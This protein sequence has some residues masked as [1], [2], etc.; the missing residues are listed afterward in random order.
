MAKQKY[1]YNKG[2]D[3][4]LQVTDE[5]KALVKSKYNESPDGYELLEVENES[6]LEEYR[7]TFSSQKK[8][9]TPSEDSG[10]GSGEN[11]SSKEEEFK[12]FE[13]TPQ[14]QQ[15]VDRTE[16]D[17]R[18]AKDSSLEVDA[19]A[20]YEQVVR[21]VA[22]DNYG[23]PASDATAS[24]MGGEEEG[25]REAISGLDQKRQEEEYLKKTGFRSPGEK[26]IFEF[27]EASKKTS[28]AIKDGVKQSL[29]L[30]KTKGERTGVIESDKPSKFQ[31]EA[32]E[33][34]AKLQNTLR[35]LEYIDNDFVKNS[36]NPVLIE[37]VE[38]EK[39]RLSAKRE[40]ETKALESKYEAFAKARKTDPTAFMTD[41]QKEDVRLRP[42]YNDK[43]AE[44][45][46]NI[47][48]YYISGIEEMEKS[49]DYK[50]EMAP[51][52]VKD[53]QEKLKVDMATYFDNL[54]GEKKF[55]LEGVDDPM[56]RA[57]IYKNE[58]LFPQFLTAAAN[59]E[60][61]LGL[62][63]TPIQ[64]MIQEMGLD[65]QDLESASSNDQVTQLFK[66]LAIADLIVE[67]GIDPTKVYDRGEGGL[68]QTGYAISQTLGNLYKG[69]KN[70]LLIGGGMER[71]ETLTNLEEA[72]STA[73]K[74]IGFLEKSDIKISDEM[75][76]KAK[77]QTVDDI[78]GLT[79]LVARL[80]P[81]MAS[82]GKGKSIA[83]KLLGK[84]GAGKRFISSMKTMEGLYKSTDSFAKK[85]MYGLALK[86]E[87]AI[88]DGITHQLTNWIH[89]EKDLGF[90]SGAAGSLGGQYFNSLLGKYNPSN[91]SLETI[92]SIFSRVASE[93]VEE[94]TEEWVQNNFDL[95]HM[96]AKDWKF[97]VAASSL[98]GGAFSLVEGK[99]NNEAD[100]YTKLYQEISKSLPKEQL[101]DI[102]EKSGITDIEEAFGVGQ[103]TD[104]DVKEKTGEKTDASDTKLAVDVE[105]KPILDEEGNQ[106]TE[107]E[108]DL[109]QGYIAEQEGETDLTNDTDTKT[110]E[111]PTTGK[112]EA[113]T[114]TEQ[115][116][117]VESDAKK[118]ISEEPS[119][120]A[121]KKEGI[122]SE[123]KVINKRGK[124]VTLSKKEV[125]EDKKIEAENKK[126][127]PVVDL[128]KRLDDW[129]KE[130]T[131]QQGRKK[132]EGKLSSLNN[133]ANKHGYTLEKKGGK[134][135]LTQDGEK[136]AT[137]RIAET[138]KDK[139]QRYNTIVDE[140]TEVQKD[141]K[142]LEE[143]GFLEDISSGEADANRLDIS[144]MTRPEFKSGMNNIKNGVR[145]S[146][147]Q[148][149]LDFVRKYN[150]EGQLPM[151]T[152]KGDKA[153]RHSVPKEFVNDYAKKAFNEKNLAPKS[154]QDF[155]SSDKDVETILDPEKTPEG[156]DQMTPDEQDFVY[157]VAVQL[158]N[159]RGA[160]LN[161][162]G[163]VY[164]YE[165]KDSTKA[166]EVEPDEKKKSI[167]A[168][169]LDKTEGLT[170][171]V[172]ESISKD[173]KEYGVIT[174]AKAIEDAT[175]FIGDDLTAAA[176]S[177]INNSN[178]YKRLPGKIKQTTQ[179][180]LAESIQ[181]KVMAIE[182]DKS[183]SESK[184]AKESGDLVEL[185]GQVLSINIKEATDSA[186]ALQG[187]KQFSSKFLE[188]PVVAV[189]YT[190]R[191]L[192]KSKT[193]GD[194]AQKE[195][196]KVSEE[197]QDINKEVVKEIN[198]KISSQAKKAVE[199]KRKTSNKSR[200]KAQKDADE[201]LGS[202]DSIIKD[203]VKK[204]GGLAEAVGDKTK[205]SVELTKELLAALTKLADALIRLGYYNFNDFKT[206]FEKKAPKS[207]HVHID[208]VWDNV[209]ENAL[210]V[211]E[212]YAKYE[213]DKA[214]KKEIAENGD[215]LQDII[216]KH[217]TEVNDYKT[218][219]AKKIV[220][221]LKLDE[222]TAQ[223]V[224]DNIQS[225]FEK[226][227]TEKK[228]QFIK[229]KLGD[230]GDGTK[231]KKAPTKQSQEFYDKVIEMTNVGAFDSKAHSDQ[232]Q[233]FLG[234]ENLTPEVVSKITGMSNDI[235]TSKGETARN[236]ATLQMMDYIQDLQ[237]FTKTEV[238][239][240]LYIANLFSG[241]TTQAINVWSNFQ[242]LAI[243]PFVVGIANKDISATSTFIK[244]MGK[245]IPKALNSASNIMKT[246][247]VTHRGINPSAR[248]LEILRKTSGSKIIRGYSK[249]GSTVFRALSAMDA[250]FYTT[251][252]EAKMAVEYQ[253]AAKKEGKKGKEV[254]K[255][256]DEQMNPSREEFSS[257][258]EKVKAE[259]GLKGSEA[260]IRAWEIMEEG[261]NETVSEEAGDYAANVT[262]TDTPKGLLG[263]FAKKLNSILDE[264]PAL[265]L[266]I[267][268]VNTPVNVL[269]RG[270][271]FTPYGIW[272]YYKGGLLSGEKSK[273]YYK[274][275]AESLARGVIGSTVFSLS[276]LLFT[277]LY[278]DED[279]KRTNLISE[280]TGLDIKIHGGGPDKLQKKYALQ[281]T[282]WIPNSVQI[283]DNFYSYSSNPLNFVFTIIGNYNDSDQYGNEMAENDKLAR[284]GAS[285][286]SM[287]A[288]M[289]DMSFVSGVSDMLTGV[290]EDP[291]RWLVKKSASI[292][293]NIVAPNTVRQI[294]K[295]WSPE[296]IDKRT[297][298][299]WFL[300]TTPFAHHFVDNKPVVLNSLG[301]PVKAYP[302]QKQF[303]SMKSDDLHS[304]LAEKEL[305]LPKIMPSTK[306]YFPKRGEDV[307]IS[308]NNEI[309]RDYNIQKGKE[310]KNL[311]LKYK[312]RI[313][314]LDPKN[315]KDAKKIKNI[316][317]II[318]D[319]STNAAK[320]FILKK[321]DK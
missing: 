103:T 153:A 265:K 121:T 168:E 142:K 106:L 47:I 315:E 129:N 209:K 162:S 95:S 130:S 157:D 277:D 127:Q 171:E 254:D 139:A 82:V 145:S 252:K 309:A 245:A 311:V 150:N 11:E 190:Q 125:S 124:E 269:N 176:N 206:K 291:A 259:E 170:P 238:A 247:F 79:S 86:G 144:D 75:K 174:D 30:Q 287:S 248:S 71:S 199:S 225:S 303:F 187:A 78:A 29:G 215:L 189:R 319:R 21:E 3:S 235:Q 202:I 208:K 276:T 280:L 52:D 60:H 57:K 184:K 255:Y 294:D 181:E 212:E 115:I 165:Y 302:G 310:N 178:E 113:T 296:L 93:N 132:N 172:K 240:S 308:S 220:D 306:I 58:V 133:E 50:Y 61:L 243:E 63:D 12:L 54:D 48:N 200:K 224:A 203:I 244:H 298:D 41:Q 314:K 65:V 98:M 264:K 261:R 286:L 101:A 137:P 266:I 123:E 136:K 138:N 158:K 122:K 135:I 18:Y 164:L 116:G 205:S 299:G 226:L 110:T 258:L 292:S 74:T 126:K 33:T 67:H 251:A 55:L 53:T 119:V 40:E 44:I 253:L 49:G 117:G 211:K 210:K 263:E 131:F 180:L 159:K 284:F 147:A 84:T 89:G 128:F 112:T 151:I 92:K 231:T 163:D 196:K 5:N 166:Q 51:Q 109:K 307:K 173:A 35:E 271:D 4:F 273:E 260:K 268:V 301:E 192:S 216:T 37:A 27:N 236:R 218:A 213:T 312:E 99:K 59:Q 167:R 285:F 179:F 316:R 160:A 45:S 38:K 62:V 108:A 32:K 120:P 281:E 175:E 111:T 272:R 81:E 20:P 313:K 282:G 242:N 214:V 148:K 14:E 140:D 91:K 114:E 233:Q 304:L 26:S 2:K 105:G 297:I 156:W 182:D 36:T 7:K 34:T 68:E 102:K 87:R 230:S 10:V 19:E 320:K 270:L 64:D 305:Y 42:K 241:L 257:I 24:T 195:K 191:A 288:F 6:D 17:E 9:E 198:K 161:E 279:E 88:A 267:P 289:A 188:N 73:E 207:M 107:K 219:L 204:S 183:I 227:A 72:K 232:I 16:L 228:K 234:I 186:Q 275:N 85:A 300:S 169:K 223:E 28:R 155:I 96:T 104:L 46:G 295:F 94:I 177:V 321:Y 80:M 250:L 39:E 1:I 221:Q 70:A 246:G 15:K 290:V 43:V 97:M 194:K 100:T 69:A 222:K 146:N 217:Y 90:F 197:V 83:A 23:I 185:L 31:L 8:K 143:G 56:E 66:E 134:Y 13:E 262:F 293:A 76:A 229:R 318:N 141:F 274:G 154:V 256:I 237:G 22:H 239:M 25:Q 317:N 278:D 283:G 77:P 201:A 118:D 249:F 152:G 149:I 193:A